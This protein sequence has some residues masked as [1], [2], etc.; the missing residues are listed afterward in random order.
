M[1]IERDLDVSA[2]AD[3]VWR[4]LAD[5]YALVGQW[6]RAVSS[7]APNPAAAPL[8]G[9]AVGGRVCTASIGEVTETITVFDPASRTLAYDAKARSM[10]FFVRGLSGHWTVR[11]AGSASEVGL[12]FEADL[13]APF[14]LLMGWAIR[15]QFRTAIDETLIDLKHYAETGQVHPDKAEALRATARREPQEAV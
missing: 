5:E 2:S 15:R 11:P 6:A 14:D 10:P 9:A 4:I 13:M 7:S 3:T 12:R 1:R 8:P